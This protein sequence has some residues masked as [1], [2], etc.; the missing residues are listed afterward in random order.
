MRIMVTGA[1][2]QVGGA[3]AKVLARSGNVVPTGRSE[4]DL[5]QPN[6]IAP[7]LDR[8]RP[9]LIVNPAAYTA[10]DRAEDEKELAFRVNAEAP[11]VM[12]RWAADHRVPLIHFST[13]YVF[14][15]T[16]TR[17]WQE[18]DPTNPL[19]TY[20]ASK[21]AGENAVRSAG[22]EHLIIRTS[23]VYAA[24]GQ[25][26]LRTIE[27]LAQERKELRIVADQVGAPT[28]AQLIADA[29]PV[30]LGMSGTPI[31]VQFGLPGGTI[32]VAASGETTWYGFAVAIVEGLKSRGMPLA[33]ER[34][35]PI[36]TEDYPTKARRPKNSRLDL[37]KL[38]K[39]FGISTPAW[40]NAL[41]VELD[42]LLTKGR[43]ATSGQ[44]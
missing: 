9:D 22:G 35:I 27:R 17:P 7:A 24:L 33:V 29:L 3:L 4:F 2:G 16:A 18:D 5:A 40:E 44:K 36:A 37:T 26:F 21:L 11:A 13:D 28:S 43:S 34:I 19:S 6:L 14:D 15:G 42:Q 38:R 10:V 31:G 8:I 1:S 41:S 12:A 32:N 25:N 20:G 39:T 30:V 23:W